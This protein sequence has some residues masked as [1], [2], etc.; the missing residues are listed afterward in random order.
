MGH[1]EEPMLDAMM[2]TDKNKILKISLPFEEL[3]RILQVRAEAL[4]QGVESQVVIDYEREDGEH[5]I[6]KAKDIMVGIVYSGM[7]S[8]N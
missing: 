4:Q 8:E 5:I 7:N 1:E 3:S 2:I 6:Y